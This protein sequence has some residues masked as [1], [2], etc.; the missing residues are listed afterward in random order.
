MNAKYASVEKFQ[1]VAGKITSLQKK[2]LAN[3]LL[4]ITLDT[5]YLLEN[6]RAQK[7]NYPARKK[8]FY[9]LLI[10]SLSIFIGNNKC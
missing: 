10:S 5:E 4:R 8:F 7:I 9:N 3:V 6:D 2:N 1:L